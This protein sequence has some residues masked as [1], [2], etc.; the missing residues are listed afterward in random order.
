MNRET[1]SLDLSITGSVPQ[2]MER[3]LDGS[4]QYIEAVTEQPNP[5]SS[6]TNTTNTNPN[7]SSTSGKSLHELL[8]GSPSIDALPPKEWFEETNKRELNLQ[9]RK[10]F[11]LQEARKYISNADIDEED[12]YLLHTLAF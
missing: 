7:N 11:M 6:A 4:I 1:L 5:N 8:N 12:Y 10:L 9:K 2:T 3:I